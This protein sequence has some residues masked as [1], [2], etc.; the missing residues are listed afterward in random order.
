MICIIKLIF[1]YV[2]DLKVEYFVGGTAIAN[3]I[4]NCKG[5]HIAVGAP[6]RISHLIKDG[7]LKTDNVRLVIFDEADKL[8]E[9]TFLE[10][11]KYVALLL[12]LAIYI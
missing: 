10:N 8:M 6:G 4:E 5:C 1:L 7:Y 11:I 12:V 9:T 3:D 2:L